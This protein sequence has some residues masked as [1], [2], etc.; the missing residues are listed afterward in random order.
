[1]KCRFGEYERREVFAL[2]SR[3]EGRRKK[4]EK[5]PRLFMC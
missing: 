5:N 3:R 1:M 4:P 2:E